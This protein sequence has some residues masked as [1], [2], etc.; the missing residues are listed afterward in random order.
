[1]EEESAWSSHRVPVAK[2]KF[3]WQASPNIALNAINI[4][5][6]ASRDDFP[7]AAKELQEQKYVDDVGGSRPTTAEAKRVTIAIDEVLGPYKDLRHMPRG[8][9][10]CKF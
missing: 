3:W 7:E 2:T 9:G 6:K 4:L 8:T 1:M 10:L 5:A